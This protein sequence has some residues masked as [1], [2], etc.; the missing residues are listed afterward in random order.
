MARD[1]RLCPAPEA[2]KPMLYVDRALYVKA[3][4]GRNEAAIYHYDLQKN[5]G[6]KP[7]ISVPG[8]DA[9]GYFVLDDEKMLGYR[10]NTDTEVTVWFD[11][12]MKAAQE[13]VDALLPKTI[14][15]IS[16]GSH[17]KTPFVL[18][19]VQRCAGQHLH[20]VQPRDKTLL[21]LGGPASTATPPACRP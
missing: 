11:D 17:S 21:R 3:R 16:V 6:G 7:I 19:D 10:V 20:A 18:V 8:F 1:R 2:F 14:N 15:T 9:D 13:E 4:N 5:H 12:A